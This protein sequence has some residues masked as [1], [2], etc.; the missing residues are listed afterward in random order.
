MQIQKT[1]HWNSSRKF[2]IISTDSETVFLEPAQKIK[3][4]RKYAEVGFV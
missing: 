2:Q 4:L 3:G 1:V